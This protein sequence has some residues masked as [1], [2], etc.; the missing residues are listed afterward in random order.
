MRLK[1]AALACA[2]TAAMLIVGLAPAA[3]ALPVAVVAAPDSSSPSNCT[4]TD[5]LG[6]SARVPG[7][8]TT[9]RPPTVTS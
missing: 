4:G 6:Y 1:T 8:R 7:C 3:S 2:S 5:C 9:S